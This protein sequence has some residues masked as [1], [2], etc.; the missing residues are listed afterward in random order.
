MSVNDTCRSEGISDISSS[1]KVQRMH[2]S[3]IFQNIKQRY[4]FIKFSTS[5]KVF[6]V[7]W[8]VHSILVISSYTLVWPYM[9]SHKMIALSI[10]IKAGR[11]NFSL[12]KAKKEKKNFYMESLDQCRRLEVREKARNVFFV[13]SLRQGVTQYRSH[14][15]QVFWRFCSDFLL[16]FQTSNLIK[17]LFHSHLLDMRLVIDNSAL[18][19]SLAIYH[20]ISNRHSWNNC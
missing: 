19:A 13:M 16:I 8:L 1:N 4:I 20:F 6:R 11:Q 10:T 12:N 18:H 3:F 15:H 14:L 5:D 7:L 2:I 17:Q 9:V